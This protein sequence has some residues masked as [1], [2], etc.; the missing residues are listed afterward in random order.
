MAFALGAPAVPS[1][2]PSL[3]CAACREPSAR[4]R[5]H[6]GGERAGPWPHSEVALTAV[7][8]TR[9]CSGPAA[10]PAVSLTGD[11]ALAWLQNA[12]WVARGLDDRRGLCIAAS[13]SAAG[14]SGLGPG[15]H[16]R[17]TPMQV[18]LTPGG[19]LSVGGGGPGAQVAPV[20]RKQQR[21]LIPRP[22]EKAAEAAALDESLSNCRPVR[23]IRVRRLL[24]KRREAP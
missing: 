9:L 24:E 3:P 20:E 7:L 17:L 14:W 19:R 10:T 1:T 16:L 2:V 21:L 22:P 15:S 12:R 13:C 5:G 23:G 4:C 8:S 6:G 18:P 11:G